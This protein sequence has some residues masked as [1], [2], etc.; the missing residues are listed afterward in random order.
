M[1]KFDDRT[2]I[3]DPKSGAVIREQH[4][5]LHKKEGE[6]DVYERDG[7]KYYAN[8]ELVPGQVLSKAQQADLDRKQKREELVSLLKEEQGS[9][10]EAEFLGMSEE[11]QDD[12]VKA[13]N[14]KKPGASPKSAESKSG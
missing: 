10:K 2:H 11:Q 12:L 5:I 9:S 14:R 4:Y 3:R 7:V 1:G 13:A 8:N 6:P